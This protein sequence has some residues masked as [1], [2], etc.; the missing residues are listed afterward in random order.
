MS[1]CPKCGND[2]LKRPQYH[3]GMTDCHNAVHPQSGEH[4]HYYCVCGYDETT[5]TRDA[6]ETVDDRR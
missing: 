3:R 1:R 2:T 5:P 4:L 6:Q